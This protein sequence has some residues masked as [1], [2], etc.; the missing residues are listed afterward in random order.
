MSLNMLIETPD[1]S[2]Y[3]LREC[4]T[5]LREAGFKQVRVEPLAGN[6]W[7]AVGYK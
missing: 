3:T 7:M 2:D 4:Q 6:D 1:G 5:W